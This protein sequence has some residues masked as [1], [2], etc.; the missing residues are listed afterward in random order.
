MLRIKFAI[1]EFIFESCIT[2]RG[3]YSLHIIDRLDEYREFTLLDSSGTSNLE[4]S[5]HQQRL[6]NGICIYL[7]HN[8]DIKEIIPDFSGYTDKEISIFKALMNVPIG[9]VVTYS[10]LASYALKNKANRYIGRTLSRNRLQLLVPCHRVVMKNRKI[11]GFTSPMG[12]K[13]KIYLLS[14]E[15]HIIRDNKI[16]DCK[17]YDFA[18]Y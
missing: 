18:K 9:Y 4:I 14:K 2:E 13:L 10:S 7:K 16:E 6:I 5:R 1:S 12:L 17:F 15:G 3:I 8:R 11:G